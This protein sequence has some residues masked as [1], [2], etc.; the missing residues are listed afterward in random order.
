MSGPGVHD[1][2]PRNRHLTELEQGTSRKC[3]EVKGDR[4]TPPPLPSDAYLGRYAKAAAEYTSERA[5]NERAVRFVGERQEREHT[6]A[7]I[8]TEGAESVVADR[9]TLQPNRIHLKPN[10]IHLCRLRCRV[11][12]NRLFLWRSF[13]LSRFLSVR[14]LGLSLFDF[15]DSVASPFA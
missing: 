14:N 9:F 3:P 1:L 6:R 4:A 15:S 10:R 13:P 11:F 12:C 7:G 8:T 2:L 5:R